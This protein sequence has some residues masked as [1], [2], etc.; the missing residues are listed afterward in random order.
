VKIKCTDEKDD[1]GGGGGIRRL[2]SMTSRRGRQE[3]D[4]LSVSIDGAWVRG[5]KEMAVGFFGGIR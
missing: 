3:W 5:G 1:P 2:E 4:Y